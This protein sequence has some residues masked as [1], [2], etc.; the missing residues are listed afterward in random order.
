MTTSPIQVDLHLPI[1]E[2]AGRGV[3]AARAIG[4]GE[5]IHAAAPIELSVA[6]AL[7]DMLDRCGKHK[8][9]LINLNSIS[10]S[11][12]FAL[13]EMELKEFLASDE[14]ESDEDE[15]DNATEDKPQKKH[16]KQDMVPLLQSGEDSDEDNEDGQDMEVTF[17][18]GLED[19]SKQRGSATYAQQLAQKQRKGDK[20]NSSVEEP[21]YFSYVSGGG[22]AVDFVPF[23]EKHALVLREERLKLGFWAS[24]HASIVH[25]EEA[26]TRLASSQYRRSFPQKL[27]SPNTKD[28]V[29][30][31][32]SSQEAFYKAFVNSMIKM[33]SI[34]GGQEVRKD[35][36]VI[37]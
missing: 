3:L 33:S 21:T 30:K 17:D 24:T 14:S 31:F 34:P 32:A 26:Y 11:I 15:N 29:S 28:L 5:L 27:T 37:N 6:S 22:G 19:T 9:P 12:A 23:F 36:R 18:T 35:C 16:K 1:T 8:M 13:A 7:K 10:E 20:R 4:A 2:S 25:S